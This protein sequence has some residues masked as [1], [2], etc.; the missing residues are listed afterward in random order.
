MPREAQVRERRSEEVGYGASDEVLGRDPLVVPLYK[1]EEEP[2]LLRRHPLQRVL[3]EVL[4]DFRSIVRR[5]RIH[6]P[7]LPA[8]PR[9][10]P[11][12][13]PRGDLRLLG[14]IRFSLRIARWTRI[15]GTWIITARAEVS[16]KIPVPALPR[17]IAASYSAGMVADEPGPG[18]THLEVNACWALLRSHEVGRLAVSIAD[19]P[20]IFPINYVV[21]HGTVVFRT[22]EGTKLAGAVQRDVA[23]EADG[24]EPDTG[25]A[26]S[27]V[28]KGRGEEI[29]RGHELLDTADLPLF[30]WHAAPKQRFV[31]IVPDE[32]S[33]RRFR[34]VGREAWR[35]RGRRRPG[36]RPNDP[37]GEK[38]APLQGR[39]ALRVGLACPPPSCRVDRKL[40]HLLGGRVGSVPLTDAAV[41]PRE[42][43]DAPVSDGPSGWRPSR[44]R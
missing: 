13:R 7:L 29:S 22:A 43:V 26:W 42:R 21:D 34:V 5:H 9:R 23:F 33:G 12:S 38:V 31:R 30:P 15:S 39:T 1:R 16:E 41:L 36:R 44:D 18:V 8:L 32:I 19:R 28:V 11:L 25:E 14:G 10:F 20:E 27:V 17:T 35:R 6:G 4:D 2:E 24:Y 40:M 3:A 37:S